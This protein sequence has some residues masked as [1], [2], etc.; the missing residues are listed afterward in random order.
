M[1]QQPTEVGLDDLFGRPAT[2]SGWFPSRPAKRTALTTWLFS[3]ILFSLAIAAV[4][5]G[6][7][8]FAGLDVPFILLA[9]TIL[10]IAT[11]KQALTMVSAG[12]L[13]VQLTGK[14]IRP[15]DDHLTSLDAVDPAEDGIALAVGRWSTRLGSAGT[16]RRGSSRQPNLLGELV[17]ERLR[18]HHGF[19]RASDPRRAREMMGEDLWR[20]LNNS[21][22]GTPTPRDMATM[23]K[24][25]EEL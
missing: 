1:T 3:R 25:I 11:I 12:T 19:T 7:L 13:P 5:Y 17:D 14:G 10:V 22:A 4:I 6:L 23:V 15:I 18:L 24:W 16:G 9:A 2:P 20:M 8:Y 21:S